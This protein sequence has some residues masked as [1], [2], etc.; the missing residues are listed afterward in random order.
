MCRKIAKAVFIGLIAGSLMVG[1]GTTK[2]ITEGIVGGRVELKKIAL[3]PAANET[4]YGGQ[5][6]QKEAMANLETFLKRHCDEFIILDFEKTGKLLE[7]L[8]G[9]STGQIDNLTLAK[10]GR[11]LGVNTILIATL[12]DIKCTAGKR[13][14]YGFRDTIPLVRLEIRV[15]AFDPQTGTILFDEAFGD[16]IEVGE[17]DWRSIRERKGYHK[18]ILNQLLIGTTDQIGETVSDQ[19]CDTPWKGYITNVSGGVITLSAGEDVG[20]AKGDVLEVFGMSGTIQGQ[21]GQIYLLS[22]PKIGEIE[23]TE[24]RANE[25]EAM[26]LE[27]SDFQKSSHV[28]LKD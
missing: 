18:E 21:E 25:A 11:V 8:V 10:F 5:A 23:I 28:Q 3:V 4:G 7:Q 24:V 14:V 9:R 2:K 20:L 13:G 15:R 6:L 19:L 22:G 26:G 17:S 12:D 27:G 1:C 16:E